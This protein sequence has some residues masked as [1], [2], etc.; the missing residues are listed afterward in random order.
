MHVCD[1][2]AYYIF[3]LKTQ[4]CSLQKK[5]STQGESSIKGLSSTNT[6]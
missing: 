1:I 2:C 3:Y 4:Q 5:L 6:V